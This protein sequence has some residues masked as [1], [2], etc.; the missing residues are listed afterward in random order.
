MKYYI[1]N[2][3]LGICVGLLSDKERETEIKAKQQ[4]SN[5]LTL[6]VIMR[7]YTKLGAL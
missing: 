5:L 2:L 7:G 6:D 1:L 3:H 4:P